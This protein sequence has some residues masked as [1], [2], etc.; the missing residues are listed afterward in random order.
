MY[1]HC[2]AMSQ[3]HRRAVAMKCHGDM[4][5]WLK[6]HIANAPLKS[7]PTLLLDNLRNTLGLSAICICLLLTACRILCASNPRSC[8]L[9]KVTC[10]ISA[11]SILCNAVQH[12]P[13]T[14]LLE[15]FLHSDSCSNPRQGVQL[16][17]A[18]T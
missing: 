7:A 3:C 9:S 6:T 2:E 1:L 5:L 12:T 15:I 14:P 11:N 18:K 16:T 17:I 4:A 8:R 13:E 10:C